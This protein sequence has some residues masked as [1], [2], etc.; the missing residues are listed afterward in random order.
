MV[1]LNTKLKYQSS[2]TVPKFVTPYKGIQMDIFYCTTQ[3]SVQMK[4]IKCNI[5][6]CMRETFY[7][8]HYPELEFAGCKSLLSAVT[9]HIKN[10]HGVCTPCHYLDMS[11]LR[12]NSYPL[13]LPFWMSGCGWGM[14]EL[15]LRRLED[16]HQLKMIT[17]DQRNR[18]NTAKR[19]TLVIYSG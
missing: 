10:T 13:T 9:K 16:M 12:H 6:W 14:G 11:H 7:I 1:P 2:H 8:Q 4:M 5:H 19:C 17:I 3:E 18:R 15:G